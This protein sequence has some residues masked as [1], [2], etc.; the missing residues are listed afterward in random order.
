[1]AV[2]K[3]GTPDPELERVSLGHAALIFDE[4]YERLDPDL[5]TWLLGVLRV[6]RNS[7]DTRYVF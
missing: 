3:P 6:L 1:M 4:L 5:F 7:L 2:S